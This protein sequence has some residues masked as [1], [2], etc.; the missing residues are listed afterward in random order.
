MTIFHLFSSSAKP[1]FL[2]SLEDATVAPGETAT[3]RCTVEGDPTPE[4]TWTRVD[5]P[6]LRELEGR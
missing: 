2:S 1:T 3:L 5:D 4:I 6:D